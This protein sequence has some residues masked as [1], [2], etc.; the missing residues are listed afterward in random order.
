MSQTGSSFILLEDFS[1]IQETTGK[2]INMLL[3]LSNRWLLVDD[4]DKSVL[5]RREF[6][7]AFGVTA[8]ASM[9]GCLGALSGRASRDKPSPS[10]SPSTQ[11]PTDS[12]TPTDTATP[13]PDFDGTVNFVPANPNADYA[14][15]PLFE[16]EG[17]VDYEL[18][19]IEARDHHYDDLE[20]WA[21]WDPQLREITNIDDP[22]WRDEIVR[23][24][25][26]IH[27]SALEDTF[28]W[29]EYSKDAPFDERLIDSNFPR[30]WYMFE[31]VSLGYISSVHNEQKASCIQTIEREK[32][33]NDNIA[34][35]HQDSAGR[36]GLVTVL[37][38]PT[39]DSETFDE[40]A[41]Y[42]V[43]TDPGER[44]QVM[45]LAEEGYV[46]DGLH[47][48]EEEG[49][50]NRTSTWVAMIG[51]T[52][53]EKWRPTVDID[54]DSVG[55]C[56]DFLSDPY[57]ESGMLYMDVMGAVNLLAEDGQI[58]NSYINVRLDSTPPGE[59]IEVS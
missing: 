7:G 49:T 2:Y 44:R 31:E 59:Y 14:V 34:W 46:N 4:G 16:W 6:L 28:I 36:H 9:T 43:E 8:T 50:E 56:M 37:E 20:H 27:D 10:G 58:A 39:Y 17:E 19:L 23:E 53:D 33:E 45:N 18:D 26:E 1:P 57:D 3:L 22:E 35:G 29:E 24:Y 52:D 25:N 47:P 11:S 21:E 38:N 40:Q 54:E 41:T 32:L 51:N 42:V 13:T 12:P 48:A 30:F 55:R 15:S 5:D